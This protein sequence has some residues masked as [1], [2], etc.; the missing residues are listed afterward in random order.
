MILNG[1]KLKAFLLGSGT[2]QGCVLLSI[3]FNI[4][5]EV[6]VTAIRQ[7]I[8]INASKLEGIKVKSSLF[9]DDMILYREN[10]KS[11]PKRLLELISEFS[12]VAMQD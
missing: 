8:K 4:T 5:L 1:G 9:A 10:P 6:L 12:K 3:L 7:D 2:R 11:P